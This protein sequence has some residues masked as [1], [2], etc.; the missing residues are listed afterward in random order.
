MNDWHRRMTEDL[1]LRGLS[2][3][4]Q[5]A[6]LRAVRKLAEHAAAMPEQIEERQ[7]RAYLL[8]LTNDRKFAP[9]S[10]RVALN[11][12]KFFYRYSAPRDWMTLLNVRIPQ[13]TT[14]P[15]V[16]SV[17]ETRQLLGDVNTRHN[18]AYLW[19]AY[20]CGLR[21]NEALHL[22]VGDAIPSCH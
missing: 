12:I 18:R 16:L 2:E 17:E 9:G 22:Q 21:L 3:R 5:Q 10:L 7:V 15:D 19:T 20:S 4:T 13:Q 1:Q 11:G 6:Y 8:H 14:L